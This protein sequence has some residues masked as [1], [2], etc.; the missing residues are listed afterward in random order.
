MAA[1][2]G[3]PRTHR[4]QRL[5]AVERLDLR[6]FIDAQH[7]SAVGRVEIEPNDV[8]HLVDKHRVSRQLEGFDAVRLQSKGP[9]D[10]PHARGRDA[11]VPR[12]TAGAPVGGSGRPVL[13]R[14]HD[15]ILDLGIVDRARRAWPRFVEQPVE[16]ALDKAST[17]L[18]DGLR[19][20]PFACRNRLIAQ[21]RRA[22]QHDPRPQCQGLRRLAPL[23][24][25][26]QYPRDFTRQFDLR[27]RA[28]RSHPPPPMPVR[29]KFIHEFPV[30]DTSV[31]SLT[32]SI[33]ESH[34]AS[35]HTIKF[36]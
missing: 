36:I 22:A 23:R 16:A 8:A 24:I 21:A 34:W 29:R 12:H 30:Q 1:P 7:Q 32:A 11:A 5:G 26:F 28:T 33:P 20:H 27:Y 35:S 2:L 14:L 18:A 31:P 6:L 9:P 15:D 13:Q 25:T 4:Q 3:L 19:R 17:P 10:A